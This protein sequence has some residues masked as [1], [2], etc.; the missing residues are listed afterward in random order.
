MKQSES[1]SNSLYTDQ[2][3]LAERE[4]SAFIAAVAELFGTDQA[5]V[6]GR[7]LARR[8]GVN[9]CIASINAPRLADYHDRGLCAVGKSAECCTPSSE[10]ARHIDNWYPGIANAIVRLFRFDALS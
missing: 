4:L 6:F 2:M 9:G 1:F 10:V 3:H 8:I 5:R 7:R